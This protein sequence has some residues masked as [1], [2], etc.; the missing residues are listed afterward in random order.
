MNKVKYAVVLPFVNGAIH[1]D[2]THRTPRWEAFNDPEWW[3]HRNK[4]CSLFTLRSLKNQ[5]CSD[6]DVVFLI[7]RED[8]QNIQVLHKA[9]LAMGLRAKVALE[10][11]GLL[12]MYKNR[13]DTFVWIQLDSDDMLDRNAVEIFQ[14]QST[15]DGFVSYCSMGHILDAKTGRLCV[16]NAKKIPPPFYSIAL[17]NT[18]LQ[19]F[20]HYREYKQKWG[21]NKHHYAMNTA[22]HSRQLSGD[23]FCVMVHGTNSISSWTNPN[24]LK[25]LGKDI[26]D[27][28]ERSTLLARF[29]LADS[30]PMI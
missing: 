9:A 20:G 1:V 7:R 16:Y 24:T 14:Q 23:L 18:A 6:F 12:E 3:A 25:K 10:I 29:G 21:L 8:E 22:V 27:K 4:V 5:R 11:E 19:S 26:L 15:Q 30:F 2:V 17:S 28:D 13:V